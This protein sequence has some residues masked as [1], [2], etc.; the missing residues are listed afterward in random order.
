MPFGSEAPTEEKQLH[1][2]IYYL[3]L[4]GQPTKQR[5]TWSRPSPT[6][7][8]MALEEYSEHS[9]DIKQGG[10][11]VPKAFIRPLTPPCWLGSA[12]SSSGSGRAVAIWARHSSE[13]SRR[14][15]WNCARTAGRREPP[16]VPG[17]PCARRQAGHKADGLRAPI[18]RLPQRQSD[19]V[20]GS[21]ESSGRR[22]ATQVARAPASAIPQ[23]T[24]CQR[25]GLPGL[26]EHFMP[27]NASVIVVSVDPVPASQGTHHPCDAR[28]SCGR[29]TWTDQVWDVGSSGHRHCLSSLRVSRAGT[30]PSL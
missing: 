11:W 19:P 28:P 4:P 23:D 22:V 29:G 24:R 10:L 30:L 27:L 26:P 2:L 15:T 7:Q 14:V 16:G 6:F 21:S 17:L 12:P 8:S 25:P 9:V 1:S 5:I 13:H 18:C 3:P 20:L